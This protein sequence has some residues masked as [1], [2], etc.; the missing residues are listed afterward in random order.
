MTIKDVAQ[1]LQVS[2]DTIKLIFD[3]TNSHLLL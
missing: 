3:T 2:W 1:H